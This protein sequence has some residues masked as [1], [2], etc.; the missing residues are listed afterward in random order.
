MKFSINDIICDDKPFISDATL[1]LNSEER[2]GRCK[3][4]FIDDSGEVHDIDITMNV[5]PP[6]ISIQRRSISVCARGVIVNSRKGYM[7]T[8]S[9]PL[10]GRCT[11][12]TYI[13]GKQKTF[14]ITDNSAV[15]RKNM[16]DVLKDF[17]G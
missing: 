9:A 6:S 7:L 16:L 14:E 3:F 1:N 2:R 10:G 13:S 15:N 17:A 11:V 4:K 8:V 12:S 5:L